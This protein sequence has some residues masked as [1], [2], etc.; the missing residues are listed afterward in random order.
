[1]PNFVSLYALDASLRYLNGVGIGAISRHADPLVARVHE[2][3]ADLGI[4]P[5]A[6]LR[7]EFPT[8]IVSFI[9]PRSE[10]IHAAL[11][12]EEIHVMHHAGRIRIAVHGYNTAGDVERLLE[13]IGRE[14]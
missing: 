11:E 13:V 3:L 2:G 1:M 6:P 8:G 4:T 9:D 7:P 5:L 14:R 10:A 12:R